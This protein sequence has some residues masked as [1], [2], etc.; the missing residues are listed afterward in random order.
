MARSLPIA[1]APPSRFRGPGS[2]AGSST[3]VYDETSG[4]DREP[5]TSL[6][7]N[8]KMMVPSLRKALRRTSSGPA[9]KVRSN[10]ETIPD[11]SETS[12][13][14]A[15]SD[16]Q[17]SGPGSG[18][19]SA[20]A[21]ASEAPAKA[22]AG[23]VALSAARAD[24]AAG[25]VPRGALPSSLTTRGFAAQGASMPPGQ[26]PHAP[27]P[28]N[29][30]A[31]TAAATGP[32]AGTGSATP[33][34]V[35]RRSPRPAYMPPPPPTSYSIVLPPNPA[36]APAPLKL[37]E[38]EP[39]TEFT[40]NDDG[41]EE[42]EDWEKVLQF[43]HRMQN[44]KVSWPCA[45]ELWEKE[46]CAR[47]EADQVYDFIVYALTLTCRPTSGPDGCI[48]ACPTPNREWDTVCPSMYLPV[49]TSQPRFCLRL[50][51]ALMI[52]L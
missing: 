2:G 39:N 3:T 32:G 22:A 9:R 34:L 51:H 44:L 21:S 12:P 30:A 7:Y 28:A 47:K 41:E 48:T 13:L 38:V 43:M 16:L 31:T 35:R 6:P 11:D 18:S 50:C 45:P 15:P 40:E 4:F 10:L 46:S 52:A 24:V 36:D 49:L 17:G 8:E 26:D 20:L 23:K 29:V 14:A 37:F 42:E 5:K 1:V 19:A 25:G 27:S 33:P